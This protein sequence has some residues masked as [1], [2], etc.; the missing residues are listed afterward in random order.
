MR[1]LIRLNSTLAEQAATTRRRG[2][3]AS[4]GSVVIRQSKPNSFKHN[5]KTL[6]H[7]YIASREEVLKLPQN[8][9]LYSPD[10][11][12]LE[13]GPLSSLSVRLAQRKFRPKDVTLITEKRRAQRLAREAKQAASLSPE[14]PK[15]LSPKTPESLPSKTPEEILALTQKRT[16][17][18][19]AREAKRGTSIS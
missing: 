10:L 16:E 9:E 11:S 13:K 19:L 4:W 8:Q 17:E 7:I 14:T 6:T 5:F 12:Y 15:S 1:A 18:R 2:V 3:T